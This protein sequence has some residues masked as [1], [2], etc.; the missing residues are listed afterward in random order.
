MQMAT[1]LILEVEA[2]L[3]GES[4]LEEWESSESEDDYDEE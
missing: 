2:V 3:A 4:E 1:E